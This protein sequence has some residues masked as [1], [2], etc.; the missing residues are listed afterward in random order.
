MEMLLYKS[1]HSKIVIE[2]E[3]EVHSEVMSF[4]Q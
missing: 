4:V 1:L 3:F 2:V